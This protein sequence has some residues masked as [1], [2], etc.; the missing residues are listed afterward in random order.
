MNKHN[1]D[2]DVY[3]DDDCDEEE[4]R[5]IGSRRSYLHDTDPAGTLS[6]MSSSQ[7]GPYDHAQ[8]MAEAELTLQLASMRSWFTPF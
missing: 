5:L 3:D 7:A 1:S 2:E 6:T 8:R 4:Q